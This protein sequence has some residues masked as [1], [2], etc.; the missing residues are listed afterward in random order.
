MF[1][2]SLWSIDNNNDIP[3]SDTGD[4]EPRHVQFSQNFVIFFQTNK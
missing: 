1:E 3:G 2:K 4:G